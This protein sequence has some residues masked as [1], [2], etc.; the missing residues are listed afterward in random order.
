M[1]SAVKTQSVP[2]VDRIFTILELLAKS[3]KGLSLA[4]L[5]EYSKMPKSSVHCLVL[6]LERR[7]YLHRQE[8][9][10]RYLFGLKL[11]GLANYA[12]ASVEARERAAPYL[13]SLLKQTGRTVHMAILEHDE[14]VLVSKVHAPGIF[15]LATWLGKSMEFHCTGLGKAMAAFLPEDV[16]DRMIAAHGLP[17]HNENTIVSVRKLKQELA[18]IR[19]SG[20]ALD[21]EED[22]IGLRCIGAPIFDRDA[23]VI[24][25]VSIA[26]TTA[27]IHAENVSL[28][29]GLVK[30]A[31]IQISTAVGYAPP[32]APVSRAAS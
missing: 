28:L 10:G 23:Q 9:T 14:P 11:F 21:D 13:S 22:E 26:G 30:A 8:R 32:E 29:A 15:P 19:R 2:A 5:V 20:F 16:V 25:A 17:R 12:L 6:T 31:G 27:E 7:G 4:E 18:R 24:A 1:A 3:R